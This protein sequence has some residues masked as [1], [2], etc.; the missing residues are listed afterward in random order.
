VEIVVRAAAV[1][2]ILW[3]LLRA[4]GKRELAEVTAFELVILV[5][6]GDIIQQGVTQEDMSVTGA[7]LA[8]STMG[9]LAVGTS[10]IGH[11]WPKSQSVLEGKPSLVVHKGVVDEEVLRMER[12]PYTELQ[13]AAR[14]R[15]FEDLAEIEWGIVEADGTFSFLTG[16]D[17]AQED[18]DEGGEGEHEL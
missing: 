13:E 5:V 1:Y 17:S 14:K 11:R 2:V 4:M 10:V 3:I 18:P 8:V 7:T 12:I 16:S 6:L 15:G 9:L